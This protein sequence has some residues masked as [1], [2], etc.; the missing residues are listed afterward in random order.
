MNKTNI[1]WCTHTWNPVTGC[2]RGCK[3]CYAKALHDKRYSAYKQGA[4]Q[5]LKQYS[6]P[7]DSIMFHPDRLNDPMLKRKEPMVIFVG[8]MTDIFYWAKEQIQAVVDVC[9]KYPQ[10]TF[11]FLSKNVAPYFRVDWPEN[12]MQGLTFDCSQYWK[13]QELFW[14]EKPPRP[15]LSIEPLLGQFMSCLLYTKAEL[16]IVGAMTGKNAVAPEKG[17]IESVIANC[18]EEKI[19]WKPNIWPYLKKYGLESV[20]EK[21]KIFKKCEEVEG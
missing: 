19:H 1:S 15:Y 12:T 4:L 13:Y 21:G 14:I 17:W 9:R 11:M 3:Y 18:P 5:N 2:K 20:I 8:S 7:F 10:H 6:V 16:I